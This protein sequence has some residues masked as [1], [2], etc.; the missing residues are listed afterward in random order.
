MLATPPIRRGR[1]SRPAVALHPGA[2]RMLLLA[3]QRK[4]WCPDNHPTFP[5]A[6]K[7]AARLL[8][9]LAAARPR[10]TF[11]I[12]RL[13]ASGFC[14]GGCLHHAGQ[15]TVTFQGRQAVGRGVPFGVAGWRRAEEHGA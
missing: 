2:R 4:P 3:Y 10:P 8:L 9:L 15:P 11:T 6:F 14:P 12:R 7:E 5:A 13:C 1:G